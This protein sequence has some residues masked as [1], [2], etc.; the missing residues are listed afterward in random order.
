MRSSSPV[1]TLLHFGA[2][3]LVLQSPQAGHLGGPEGDLL[4]NGE[5]GQDGLAL[6]PA[7]LP[8]DGLQPDGQDLCAKNRKLSTSEMMGGG[9]GVLKLDVP[10]YDLYKQI[11]F[12]NHS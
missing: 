10:S 5:R 12:L 8:E 2:G 9:V 4:E 1:E 3:H 11:T 6:A 7:H